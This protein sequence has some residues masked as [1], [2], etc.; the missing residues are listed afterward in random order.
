MTKLK[1]LKMTK[2]DIFK[3]MHGVFGH[4]K[5]GYAVIAMIANHGMIGFRD[6]QGI[7]PL[8]Y[9][10]KKSAAGD[11]YMFASESV[12]LDVLGFQLVS[13]VKPGEVVFIDLK[14]RLHKK[15]I[16][17]SRYAPC[18][19]EYVY[20]AR[21]DSVIDNIGVHK[22]RLRMGEYLAKQIKKSGVP[23]DIVTPVPDSARTSALPLAYELG[24]PYREGLVK[25]RYIGRTFI[26]PGQKKRK[27]SI[28]YKLNAV[29]FE[30]KNKNVLLVDDSIVRGNTSRQI[31]EMVRNAGAN[32]VYFA[33]CAPPLKMPCVYGVDVPTR[34]DFIAYKLDIEGIAKAIGADNETPDATN[35]KKTRVRYCKRPRHRGHTCSCQFA[36]I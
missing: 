20:L 27:R 36:D 15:Q 3:A 10:V 28:H 18:I 19:F 8:V 2:L 35:R 14:G 33:S 25:N 30:I 12:A 17:K 23:I 11:E 7:R 21:P 6:P 16:V 5:G 24:V 22:A 34:K 13:D 29:P 9:G 26:M 31:I 1:K 32:K 4:L